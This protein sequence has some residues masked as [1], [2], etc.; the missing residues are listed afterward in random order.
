MVFYKTDEEIELIRESC[1]LVCKALA[2][3]GTIIRP[4]IK[5]SEIDKAAE[6][7]IRDHGAEPGFKGYRGFPATLC[8]S[9]NEG[10]VHGIP[11]ED[12]VFN[13]GDV[14]SVDCGVFMNGFYGDSAYTFALG[15][16]DE[17]IMEL[18]RVTNTSLYKAIDTAVAGKRLGDIGFAVQNYVEK[19]HNYSVVRELVGHGIGRE[20][21]EKPE[22]A[23]YGKRGRGAKLKEGLVIAIEPMVNLGKREVRTAKDGWTVI[24]KDRKPSAH[25]EHTI[26][27]RKG[28]ADILSDHRLIEEAIR[29]NDNVKVVELKEAL[30]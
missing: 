4:G 25:F 23:N 22:V 2:H 3:V 30:A 29:A 19:E 27:V 24:A 20:L 26:A 11:T 15:D 1:L 9:V 12:Q 17:S 10:V 8:V 18:L 16:V 21:H 7:V 6:T 14:V 13:D 28:P 5:G